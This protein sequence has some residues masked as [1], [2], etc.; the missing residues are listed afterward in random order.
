MPIRPFAVE[1]AGGVL[2]RVQEIRLRQ[3]AYA[4]ERD[5]RRG[6]QKIGAGDEAE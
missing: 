6:A 5:R 3:N 4:K 2:C 1:A